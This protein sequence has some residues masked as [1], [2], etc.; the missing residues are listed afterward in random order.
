MQYIWFI[1]PS[2]KM[3]MISKRKWRIL[4]W[5]VHGLNSEIHQRAVFSKINESKCDIICLQEMNCEMFDWSLN[6]KFYPKWFN[7]FVFSPRGVLL[8]VSLCCGTLLFS[9]GCY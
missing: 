8:V 5:N 9:L 3:T 1:Y 6:H 2:V 7:S 4:C